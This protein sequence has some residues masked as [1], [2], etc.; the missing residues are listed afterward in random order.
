MYTNKFHELH[1]GGRMIRFRSITT[2][3]FLNSLLIL[4]F[5]VGYV[6]SGANFTNDLKNDGEMINIAGSIRYRSYRLLALAQQT[7]IPSFQSAS[8]SSSPAKG[9]IE[10]IRASFASVRKDLLEDADS[11]AQLIRH[12]QPLIARWENELVPLAN[13]LMLR[14]EGNSQAIVRFGELTGDFVKDVDV[15]VNM[16]SDHYRSQVYSF[17]NRR[18]LFVTGFLP[19]FLM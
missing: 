4:V 17:Q 19:I 13:I 18:I 5:V 8:A 7:H 6:I 16:M 3:H 10:R 2:Q 12:L 9:E 15:L 14:Q 1:F 11:H